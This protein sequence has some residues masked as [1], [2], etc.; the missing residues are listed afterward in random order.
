[1]RHRRA[2]HHAGGP[3]GCLYAV[4]GFV[5]CVGFVVG[6]WH[7]ATDP[8]VASVEPSS[9]AIV[10]PAAESTTRPTIRPTPHRTARPTRAPR[11]TAEPTGELVR[12]LIDQGID[13]DTL[14]IETI[15]PAEYGC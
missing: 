7:V 9:P 1:M 2:R 13:P 8:A 11:V 15:D 12:C 10:R 3:L 4:L 14:D 5:A 6:A